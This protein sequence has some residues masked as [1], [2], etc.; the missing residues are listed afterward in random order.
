MQLSKTFYDYNYKQWHIF[1]PGH[2]SKDHFDYNLQQVRTKKE[3]ASLVFLLSEY[4]GWPVLNKFSFFVATPFLLQ[5]LNIQKVNLPIGV[6]TYCLYWSNYYLSALAYSLFFW[7]FWF[8][9]SICVTL[10][11]ISASLAFTVIVTNLLRYYIYAHV[12]GHHVA[13]RNMWYTLFQTTRASFVRMVQPQQQ[14]QP[15]LYPVHQWMTVTC[16]T[17]VDLMV[18]RS[19]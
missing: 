7:D 13:T 2:P 6:K 18:T 11:Y 10:I 8:W 1:Q 14:Q 19:V 16:I 17:P 3:L 9:F 4:L 12:L 5:V 15:H